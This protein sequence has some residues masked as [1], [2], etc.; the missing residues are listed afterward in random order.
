M[1]IAHRGEGI[2]DR[3]L[4]RLVKGLAIG[5]GVLLVAFS[6]TYYLG[7][8]PDSSPSLVDRQVTAAEDA[9]KAKPQSIQ[10]R[11]TLAD[12]YEAAGRV[13]DAIAQYQEILKAVPDSQPAALG[14]A[15][16]LQEKGDLEGAKKNYALVIKLGGGTEFAVADPN[17]EMA[18]FQL[19]TIAM[20][21]DDLTTALKEVQSALTIDKGD[22]DA[23]YL[24][25]TIQSKKGDD[26]SAVVSLR[27][28]LAFV[29]I[30]WC[31]PYDALAA[32][33]GRLK[34]TT[35]AEYAAA[36]HD[37]CT[38]NPDAATSRLEP[39]V[40]GPSKLDALLGLGLVAESQ[41]D[42]AAAIGWYKKALAVDPGNATAQTALGR[43]STTKVS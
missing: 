23:Q 19:A 3:T 29:P 34:N 26:K 30:G 18:H 32:A 10:A 37:F 41:S 8:R 28:A 6:I 33:Y 21:Q 43:L 22:A 2:S 36:M 20:S 35:G 12:T 13:D 42:Q 38:G 31:E 4:R 1:A 24:L 14:L 40:T 16:A 25:A 27:Q 5:L 9:V 15:N 7:Q 39:L 11:Q 17:L